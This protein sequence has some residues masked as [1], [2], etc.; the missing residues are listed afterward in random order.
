MLVFFGVYST[1]FSSPEPTV[2]A[3]T[4]PMKMSSTGPTSTLPSFFF[5][6]GAEEGGSLW[7]GFGWRGLGVPKP[8]NLPVQDCPDEFYANESPDLRVP[9]LPWALQDDW[10]CE[11]VPTDVDVTVFENDYLRA[12]ITPQWGSKIWSLYDKKR[13][14]QLIYNNPAHQPSN[15]G[16]R[17][18][19]TSGGAEWNWAPGKVG[20]SV[21]S[22]SDA[23]LAVL[24]TERG[25]VLRTWEYDRQ[26]HTV[27]SVDIFLANDT[28]WAHPRIYNTN[29]VEVPGYWWTC[30]AMKGTPDS[31]IVTP[32]TLSVSPCSP[33]P[34]GSVFSGNA[35]FRG[36]ESATSHT[37]NCK[38]TQ[39]CAHQD[40][41][42]YLGNIPHSHDFFMYIPTKIRPHISHV[43]ADGWTLVHSHPP[44]IRGT[45]F[46]QW[47]ENKGGQ[48]QQG[49]S[50]CSL[51]PSHRAAK[52]H[53][54]LPPPRPSPF[55][56]PHKTL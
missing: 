11:R 50:C 24:D 25:P 10:G 29:D 31:R 56:H 41:N 18:A 19:W 14:R 53:Y 37:E 3:G 47:G 28:L 27:W 35:S 1:S 54:S 22:E 15:I 4:E 13:K 17:K 20:H 52:H 16:Y 8:F 46:F 48:F 44:R 43:E 49:A 5:M 23:Y 9:Q 12:A 34:H 7:S 32:A 33:W 39:T 51:L 2:R 40:D 26:N 42:S 45:K 21:F 38:Q 55:P 36:V 30:V 6:A